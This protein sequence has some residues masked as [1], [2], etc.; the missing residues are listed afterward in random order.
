MKLRLA[1][2]ACAIVGGCAG[3]GSDI[4]PSG[5]SGTS[6]SSSSAGAG[7]ATSTAT[8][9][10]PASATSN[11]TSGGPAGATST[12]TS[13]GPG[14]A[15]GA[16]T[17]SGA[18]GDPYDTPVTCTSMT[19]YVGGNDASMQPGFPCENCHVLLG[20]ASGHTFDVSGTVYP[21]AHE[22]DNCN[23]VDVTG[24]T[25]VI[26]DKNGTDF[27]L[28]VNSVGNFY[29]DDALGFLAFAGPLTTRVEY[30][31]KVRK[32][33]TPLTTTGDCNACHTVAGTQSAPGRIMLPDGAPSARRQGPYSTTNAF[34]YIDWTDSPLPKSSVV[35]SKSPVTTVFPLSF[36]ATP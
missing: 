21:T 20:A 1:L 3:V 23:G 2:L 22:T 30:N 28:P 33:L 7:G 34:A 26:T 35:S 19:M 29:H 4:A 11:A 12:T 32:M 5:V 14:G 36:M 15:G 24:A 16:A 6:G 17:I 9:G 10:G 18:G 25:V 13:G 27:P 31:G 8:S